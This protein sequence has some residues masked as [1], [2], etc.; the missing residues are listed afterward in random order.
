MPRASLR[1]PRHDVL[2]GMRR[3]GNVTMSNGSAFFLPATHFASVVASFSHP[4]SLSLRQA[5]P[6]PRRGGVERRQAHSSHVSRVRG[7][8]IRVSDTRAVPLQPGRPLGAPP[9]RFSAADPRCRLRQW[10]TGAVSDCPRQGRNCPGGRG[11]D[12]PGRGF[13]PQPRTPLLAPS[14]GRL[15]RRPLLSQDA[16]LVTYIRY[17]VNIYLHK[18]A[19]TEGHRNAENCRPC[20]RTARTGRGNS[21]PCVHRARDRRRHP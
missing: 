13:A 7:A 17:V 21:P 18:V 3:Y 5:N 2:L 15:R 6:T 19:G 12:L 8:T 16:N 11:P 9:W 1:S 4:P 14:A 20:P 10:A